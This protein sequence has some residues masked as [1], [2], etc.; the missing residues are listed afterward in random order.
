MRVLVCGTAARVRVVSWGSRAHG[1]TAPPTP[2]GAVASPPPVFRGP[3]TLRLCQRHEASWARGPPLCA[4]GCQRGSQGRGHLCPG[5]PA[6]WAQPG[7]A[8]RLGSGQS[9][10]HTHGLLCSLARRARRRAAR[11]PLWLPGLQ[12]P[13][14][15][16]RHG[17]RGDPSPPEGGRL[18]GTGPR[19]PGLGDEGAFA[20]PPSRV[21]AG[22]RRGRVGAGGRRPHT[23]LCWPPGMWAPLR[24]G[25]ARGASWVACTLTL[26]GHVVYQRGCRLPGDGDGVPGTTRRHP[27]PSRRQGVVSP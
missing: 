14:P 26:S 9:P 13:P 4:R 11:I 10:G 16:A 5:V 6:R 25:R 3:V 18:R 12:Q 1:L 27:G 8:G 17:R 22:R 21:Q 15:P 23:G 2:R 7:G 20:S 19:G 24:E